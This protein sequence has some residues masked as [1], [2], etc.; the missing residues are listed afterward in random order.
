M[1]KLRSVNNQ[2]I[3]IINQK[4]LNPHKIMMMIKEKRGIFVDFQNK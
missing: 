2:I 4:L 3:I 1:K